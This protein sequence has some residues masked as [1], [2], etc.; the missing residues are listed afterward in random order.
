VEQQ[1]LREPLLYLSLYLKTY[2]ADC[3]RLR[4]EV[5][6]HGAWEAWLEFF[7]SGVAATANNAHDSALRIIALFARD[8][9]RIVAAGEQAGSMLLV[10]KL[11]QRQPFVN[12][13]QVCD[14]T[15]LSMP[16]ANSALAGL[17]KLHL[18]REVTGKRRGR[19]YAYQDYLHILDEGTNLA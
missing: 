12:A 11:L 8:R 9:D 1:V 2:R 15:G 10:H 18:V 16:T 4:Q 3:Y 19:V 17:E 6:Q 13:A 14:K 7:L 5:R